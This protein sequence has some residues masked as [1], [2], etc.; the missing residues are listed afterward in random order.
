MCLPAAVCHLQPGEGFEAEGS[1]SPLRSLKHSFAGNYCR[2]LC[3]CCSEGREITPSCSGSCFARWGGDFQ[4]LTSV[5]KRCFYLSCP[6]PPSQLW[7]IFF[8]SV[9]KGTAS[10]YSALT[11]MD[12]LGEENE[13]PASLESPVLLSEVFLFPCLHLWQQKRGKKL[14]ANGLNHFST[15]K[16][17]LPLEHLDARP[18]I[19]SRNTTKV[20]MGLQL[21]IWARR[22][23]EPSLCGKPGMSCS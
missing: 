3:L 22:S 8:S 7:L 16:P 20:V 1:S 19:S 18:P 23:F 21:L 9:T 2:E 13:A 10:I 14:S 17:C 15:S 4:M 5:S 6:L 12:R 11:S